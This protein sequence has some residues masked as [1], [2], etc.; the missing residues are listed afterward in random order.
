MVIAALYSSGQQSDPFNRLDCFP[1]PN[2]TEAAC[3]ARGC[4]WQAVNNGNPM[5]APFCFYLQSMG[6]TAVS[7]I[8][9]CG[10]HLRS[11]Q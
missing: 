10:R 6:Y 9:Q 2:G 8:F 11:H 5:N 7:F 3:V 4:T 1:D